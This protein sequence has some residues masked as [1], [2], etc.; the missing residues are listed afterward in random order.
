MLLQMAKPS[1]RHAPVRLLVL[2][3]WRIGK[4]SPEVKSRS[5]PHF[6]LVKRPD[7]HLSGRRLNLDK[8]LVQL[9]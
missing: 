8:S 5:A 2:R 3:E 4:E 6:G 7:T 1:A 9:N